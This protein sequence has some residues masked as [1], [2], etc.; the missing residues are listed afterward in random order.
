MSGWLHKR[1]LARRKGRKTIKKGVCSGHPL[2]KLR[3]ANQ[4]RPF[5]ILCG[6]LKST[7]KPASASVRLRDLGTLTRSVLLCPRDIPSTNILLFVSF[8]WPCAQI[9]SSEPPSC[10]RSSYT[11]DALYNIP[12]MRLVLRATA[13]FSPAPDPK[14]HYRRAR[15]PQ[16]E[17]RSF[18]LIKLI[19]P[20]EVL[21]RLPRHR[22]RGIGFYRA[23]LVWRWKPS[24]RST[25]N[26]AGQ[27]TFSERT[28]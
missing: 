20:P 14:T 24:S 22:T 28:A 2:A 18:M 16:N 11:R 6:T 26:R 9:L 15:V 13:S 10:L 5:G 25:F 7:V 21:S 1:L 8:P 27:T 23:V 4:N 19:F 3:G 12:Q 17:R